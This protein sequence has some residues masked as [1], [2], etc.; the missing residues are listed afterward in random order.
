MSPFPSQKQQEPI[1][2][3][4]GLQYWTEKK[5][6]NEI[7]MLKYIDQVWDSQGLL[8]TLIRDFS[9]KMIVVQARAQ[10]E[11]KQSVMEEIAKAGPAMKSAAVILEHSGIQEN[12]LTLAQK[13]EWKKTFRWLNDNLF[14]D[15][16]IWAYYGV[17]EIRRVVQRGYLKTNELPAPRIAE[18]FSLKVYPGGEGRTEIRFGSEIDSLGGGPSASLEVSY[19]DPI[20]EHAK[21]MKDPTSFMSSTARPYG[22]YADDNAYKQTF[23]FAL[24]GDIRAVL[25]GDD[26]DTLS[27]SKDY[28]I[29][30]TVRGTMSFALRRIAKSPEASSVRLHT[31]DIDV[32]RN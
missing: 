3:G 15:T 18:L 8:H 5:A 23:R 17:P 11:G 16:E 9:E 12:P 14:I 27:L 28:R 32:Q 31:T 24:D 25:G 2:Y 29:P 4:G 22:R 13:Y 6:K 1:V 20:L 7:D 19:L 21:Y 30:E 26:L 10:D